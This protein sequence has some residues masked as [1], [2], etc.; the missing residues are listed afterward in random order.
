[1]Q[2]QLEKIQAKYK[3]RHDRHWVDHQFQFGDQVWLHINKDKMIGEGKNLR[4]ILYS[5]FK[6]LENI[7]TN[8]FHLDLPSYMQM[9]LV[10]NVEHL[11]LYEPP[12]IMD[13][14]GSIY[15]LTID[16]FAPK[17]LDELKE[18]VILNR[19]IMTSQ[20]GDVEYLRV[21]LKWVKPSKAKWIE[22]RRNDPI[23]SKML[24]EVVKYLEFS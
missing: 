19:R 18:D 5:P 15:A 11:K 6:I 8:S 3:A 12:M 7:G 13:A 23:G 2:E 21:F 1:V 24:T 17:Y 14:D 10:V 20:R 4:T 16:D 22:I 9:Y